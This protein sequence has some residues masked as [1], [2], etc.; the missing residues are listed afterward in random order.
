MFFLPCYVFR[1][2]SLMGWNH[3][4]LFSIHIRIHVNKSG[5]K[6][7]STEGLGPTDIQLNLAG[8]VFILEKKN[9]PASGFHSWTTSIYF[10][11]NVY[12]YSVLCNL[13]VILGFSDSHVAPKSAFLKAFWTKQK[14]RTKKKI[15]RGCRI[16]KVIKNKL[17]PKFFCIV[18]WIIE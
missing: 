14:K 15:S 10:S 18:P 16:R 7:S 9:L 17:T 12:V 11:W 2:V 8:F 5:R 1:R 3:N 4:L 6:R 13:I